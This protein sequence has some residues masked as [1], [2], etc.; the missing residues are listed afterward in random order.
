MARTA[1]TVNGTPASYLVSIKWIDSS[2]DKRSDSFR[3][4][5]ADY[6][7]AEI[8]SLVSEL[9]ARSNANLYA[10]GVEAEYAAV[11]SSGSAVD[12]TRE[13]VYQNIVIH[14]KNS[15]G[16]S[17]RVYWPAPEAIHFVAGSDNVD[18]EML[19]V[20][21]IIGYAEAIFTGYTAISVRY[22]ERSEINERVAL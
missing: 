1:P 4:L 2:G 6:V 20:Q 13:S 9:G 14:L 7:D 5:A 16:D 21:N 17:R 8:E 10:V 3:L 12:A 18:V 15:A 22:T 19:N 11:P